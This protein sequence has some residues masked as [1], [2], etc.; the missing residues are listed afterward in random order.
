MH[1]E[2]IQQ[3]ILQ[4]QGNQISLVRWMK[5]LQ[6]CSKY[7]VFKGSLTDQNRISVLVLYSLFYLCYV[8]NPCTENKL[9]TYKMMTKI[10]TR[11][12]L[13]PVLS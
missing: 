2:V 6:T 8:M 3:Q 5:Y 4:G 12:N 7:G 9:H 11:E 10:Q 13:K 1:L